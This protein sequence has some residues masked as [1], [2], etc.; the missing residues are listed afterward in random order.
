MNIKKSIP[1]AYVAWRAGTLT[2][3][4][5]LA[6]QSDGIYS[7]ALSFTK[8]GSVLEFRSIYDG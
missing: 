2:L 1:P 6:H 3:F 8:S 5:V 7:W 4:V